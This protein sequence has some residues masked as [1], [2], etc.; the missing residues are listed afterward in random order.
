[1]LANAAAGSAKNITEPADGDIARA[2]REPVY[3][4]VAVLEADIGQPLLLGAAGRLAQHRHRQ[5]HP[6]AAPWIAILPAAR[7][8]D[9]VPQPMSTTRSARS[10]AAAVSRWSVNGASMR[11]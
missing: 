11:W 2:G 7:V 10:M 5:V 8:V 1:M 4:R 9:P 6:R 3:L